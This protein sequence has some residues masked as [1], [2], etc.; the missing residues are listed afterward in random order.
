MPAAVKPAAAALKEVPLVNA[1]LDESAGEIVLHNRYNIGIAV[2]TPG[3]L[4]VPVVADADRKDLAQ[5]A[6]DIERVS[7]DARA[8]KPRLE[9]LRGGTFTVTS[10]GGIGG[11]GFTPINF[12]AGDQPIGLAAGDIDGDG[13]IDVAVA[14][15]YSVAPLLNRS[16]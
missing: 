13:K 10:I 16:R 12:V 15:W 5:I 8:G 9:D 11:T 6:R 4:V 1:S 2:A 14:S 7:A 3:G